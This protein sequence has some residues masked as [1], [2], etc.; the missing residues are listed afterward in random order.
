LKK[1]L[2]RVGEKDKIILDVD[3][4]SKQFPDD[5]TKLFQLM[6]GG[7]EMVL[8]DEARTG[9]K[10]ISLQDGSVTSTIPDIHKKAIMS[11]LVQ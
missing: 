4:T 6:R 1:N 11:I 10:I 2:E 9:I 5:E 3:E 7:T 8:R